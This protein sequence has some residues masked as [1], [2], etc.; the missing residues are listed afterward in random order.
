MGK[1][2]K[3]EKLLTYLHKLLCRLPKMLPTNRLTWLEYV[4]VLI[5]QAIR[6]PVHHHCCERTH[7]KQQK[8]TGIAP[9]AKIW[10]VG[11][12]PVLSRKAALPAGWTGPKQCSSSLMAC[13]A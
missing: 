5:S 6:H 12:D 3:Q 7:K 13:M 10:A 4:K 8:A 2:R 1:E 9:V 11:A